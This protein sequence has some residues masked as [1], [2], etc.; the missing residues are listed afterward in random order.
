MAQ[1]QKSNGC[2]VHP[3]VC[4]EHR[5]QLRSLS[6]SVG[7]SP[8]VWGTLHADR[9]AQSHRIG[10]SPRVWGTLIVSDH[11]EHG[12]SV[13]PHVCGEHAP[14]GR[15]TVARLRFIPTCV[16]NTA[17][18]AG[19]DRRRPV[20]PHVC[21]E[22]DPC[23]SPSTCAITG[24]S[25]RVWGTLSIAAIRASRMPVHPHVRGEHR[26]RCTAHAHGTRFIP[27]CVGNT[28]Q[29]LATVSAVHRFIPTCV[30]NMPTSHR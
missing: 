19:S 2:A 30:G 1:D 15:S 7:P 28:R 13:H 21:G 29:M 23:R 24:S 18:A 14:S 11:V 8:R 4:G 16:G 12:P 25:P 27:T 10:S 22:H 6:P 26:P 17:M 9:S 20:H 3:H 5:C